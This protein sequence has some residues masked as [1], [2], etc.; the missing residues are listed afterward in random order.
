MPGDTMHVG[1]SQTI[2]LNTWCLLRG[3]VKIN[4]QVK[5]ARVSTVAGALGFDY[6]ASAATAIVSKT[7]EHEMKLQRAPRSTGAAM[8]FSQLP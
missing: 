3:A 4:D 2:E 5:T 6:S 7:Q 1:K 8:S